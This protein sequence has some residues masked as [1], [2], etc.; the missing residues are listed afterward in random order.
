MGR[1]AHG[2]Q[3]LRS[4]AALGA[5]RSSKAEASGESVGQ[6]RRWLR[7]RS[8]GSQASGTD[9]RCTGL[10]GASGRCRARLNAELS[11]N[12]LQMVVHRGRG[13]AKQRGD[14]AVAL[15]FGDPLE[16]FG[17]PPAQAECLQ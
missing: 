7:S 8:D 11:V 15:A 14:F 2:D 16:H 12:M 3:T 9:A 13:D 1:M 10:E 6:G 4:Q 5:D 17:L